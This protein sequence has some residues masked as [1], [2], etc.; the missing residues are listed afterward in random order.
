MKRVRCIL[1][2]VLITASTG[3]LLAQEPFMDERRERLES[4]R[5]WKMTEFME[6]TSEQSI[7]FFPK[8]QAFE[9]S[10]R[11]QQEQ[12]EILLREINDR[13]ENQEEEFTQAEVDQLI[14][15]LMK[16]QK[17]ILEKRQKFMDSLED[18]LRP[19]Q[20]AKFIIFESQFKNRLMRMMHPPENGGPVPHSKRRK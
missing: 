7:V 9:K 12:Q 17:H 18:D 16:M 3:A 5:I 1:I 20:Q 13:L 15:D 2:L 11:E 10:L 8:L 19:E 4:L 6:L 14:K